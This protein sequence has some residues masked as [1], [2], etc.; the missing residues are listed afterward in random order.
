M[1]DASF[2]KL[3]A[4]FDYDE[5]GHRITGGLPHYA[6]MFSLQKIFDMEDAPTDSNYWVETPKLD[7]AAISALYIDGKFSLGLTR[8]DGIT[9]QDITDKVAFLVPPTL[10]RK[11]IV[12]ITGEVMVPKS[13]PNPRN[14]AAGALNL[15]NLEEFA[16]R[17]LV[18]VAYGCSDNPFETWTEMME[19]LE[20]MDFN[21]VLHFD[22]TDYPTDGKVF[23]I[24]GMDAF[25][26]MGYT[27]KHPR[28]AFALKEKKDGVITTLVN[29][30]WQVGKSGVVSPVA[31]LLPI[32]IEDAIVSRAT[33]HNISYIRD[34]NLEIDCEVEVIRA[35]EIIPRV[36]RRID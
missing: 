5:V 19:V 24:D 23:R 30:V 10:K 13:L 27:S 1:S 9:G 21:T 32:M 28:G 35:G 16:T 31:I 11:G 29:V 6:Q 3:A 33:L 18:F 8:G 14:L 26:N 4:H 20:L 12:Q 17:P 15:K 25:R 36:V 22:T 34:L 2:D 7:G